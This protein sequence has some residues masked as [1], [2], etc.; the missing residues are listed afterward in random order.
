[1]IA[2]LDY[3]ER[4]FDEYN[5]QIFSGKLATPPFEISHARRALGQ[6]KFTRRRQRDGSWRYSGLRFMISD[7]RD[8]PQQELDDVIIHEM[9][10]Y[11][12]LSNQLQD[13]SP[14]GRLFTG[15]MND[16]NRR[17]GRHI[18]ISH[19]ETEDGSV[20]SDMSRR[21]HLICV[22][23][24]RDGNLGITVTAGTQLFRLWDAI[25]QIPDVAACAWYTTT[26]PYFNRYP[27]AR[28]LKIYKISGPDLREHL[29][30][31]KSLVRTGHII[32][33]SSQLQ[34]LP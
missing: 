23:R 15:L 14:H 4:K 5:R 24:L 7:V 25:P 32:K 34:P 30:G 12:I 11:Y 6:V 2:T 9:I 29:K 27:R 26:D 33:V 18:S 17:Y 8:M 1:M 16:I 3:I 31:A 28:T 13:T 20:T 10:H 21:Q 22:S 19:R